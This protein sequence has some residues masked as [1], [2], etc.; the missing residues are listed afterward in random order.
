VDTATEKKLDSKFFSRVEVIGHRGVGVGEFNKP[1]SIAIDRD[2]NIYVVD[3]TA[4]VQKFSPDGKFLLL[5]QLMVTGLGKPKGMGRDAD[6]NI[7]VVEPHYQKINIFSPD[8]KLVNRWGERGTN[9][10]QLIM[11][12]S[13][14]VNSRGNFLIS[15]Y[16]EVD[17]VQEFSPKGDKLVQLIGHP[18]LGNGEFNRAEGLDVDAQD[19]IYVADSCNHR[20]QI[21]S[22]DGKFL[23]SYGKPGT[24]VG[25]MSYPYD[26]RVDKAGRQYVCEFENSRIQ[27]F[28][29]NGKS[30]EIIGGPGYEPGQFSNPYAIAL[31]S[32][33]NLYVADS[34][35]HR[36]QKFVRKEN[37]ADREKN[38]PAN[39]KEV[40]AQSP[41]LSRLRGDLGL[42]S[43]KVFNLEEVVARFPVDVIHAI[44]LW[45]SGARHNL[46]EV[47]EPGLLAQGSPQ[48]VNFGLRVATSSRLGVIKPASAQ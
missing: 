34:Q 14:A 47:A 37:I 7:I 28:D 39:L 29:A 5:W 6:G 12:R 42:K 25:E 38:S 8:G 43:E 31:D 19:R 20:I 32:K 11:P 23:R 22:P 4:R 15:E 33:G 35:N 30:L 3:M 16:S 13:V 10:G 27:I 17:R 1:R 24:G 36:V 48:T 21:F 44:R 26:V 41:R 9:A 45:F 46:F 2:D 18:G 40:A